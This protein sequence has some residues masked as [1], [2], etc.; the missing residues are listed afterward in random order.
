VQYLIFW[1]GTPSSSEL[2][3]LQACTY[4]PCRIFPADART[5]RKSVAFFF[6]VSYPTAS[7][8]SPSAFGGRDSATDARSIRAH[9]YSTRRMDARAG[10]AWTITAALSAVRGAINIDHCGAENSPPKTC[11]GCSPWPSLLLGRPACLLP[12][13]WLEACSNAWTLR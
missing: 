8:R 1:L 7:H 13:D 11:R 9:G 12:P 3:Q 5:G 10:Q 2:L 4:A 6:L